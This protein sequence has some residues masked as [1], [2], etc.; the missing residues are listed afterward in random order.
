MQKEFKQMFRDKSILAMM[1]VL[2]TIQLGILPLAMDFEVK[3]L[4]LVVVDADR[5]SFSQKLITKIGSSGYFKIVAA[6]PAYR[7]AIDYIERG[8]AD[9]VLEVPPSFEKSLVREGTQKLNIS[10]DAINGTKSGLGSAYLLSVIKDFNKDILLSVNGQLQQPSTIDVASSVWFNP[11]ANFKW[12]VVPGVLVLLV[13]IVGGFLASLNI[14][15]EKELGTIEQ[16]N[17]TPIKKWQFIFGKLFPFWL[18]GLGV[19][20]VGLLVARIFYNV[21]PVGSIALLY[22]L[23]GIYL[24]AILGF[25]LLISTLADNQ[26]QS[27]FIT[28]FF[29]MIFVLMSGLF[30][31]VESMPGWARNISNALPITHFMRA[32]RMVVI[33]GSGFADISRILLYLLGFAV[34]LNGFAIYNYRKTS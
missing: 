26:L 2:P 11:Y 10:V 30:T 33:K 13:T 24:I 19:F 8:K 6:E 29:I 28:Y 25:G 27:M 32:I 22:L 17:V 20:T 23:A 31:S 7:Q 18:V 1:F 3:K 21:V 34:L 14:V 4:N 5:S 12:Y 9:V 16:I 15:K